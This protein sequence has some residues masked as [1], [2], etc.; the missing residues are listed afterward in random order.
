[1]ALVSFGQTI[2]GAGAG[3]SFKN[4]TSGGSA[5]SLAISAF[6]IT[7]LAPGANE[8]FPFEVIDDY[9]RNPRHPQVN[10]VNALGAQYKDDFADLANMISTGKIVTSIA[11]LSGTTWTVGASSAFTA[12]TDGSVFFA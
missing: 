2:R 9:V 4:A 12:T 7:Q 10:L 6:G 8:I 11:T 3:V 1:M 5:T